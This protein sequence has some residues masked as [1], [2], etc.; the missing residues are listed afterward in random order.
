M[1]IFDFFR[2]NKVKSNIEQ[3]MDNQRQ[4]AVVNNYYYSKSTPKKVKKNVKVQVL[5]SEM[6]KAEEFEDLIENNYQAGFVLSGGISMHGSALC[7]TL[8]K[9]I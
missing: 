3:T 8:I 9:E 5:F 1:N 2:G 6:S 7:A 4:R